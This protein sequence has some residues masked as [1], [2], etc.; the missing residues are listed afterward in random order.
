MS[1]CGEIPIVEGNIEVKGKIAYASQKPWI[2]SGT[3]RQN[4]L[5]GA[6]LN[7]KR[8]EKTID[9]CALTEVKSNICSLAY[10]ILFSDIW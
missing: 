4:I 8:Y 1:I 3:V 10:D 6:E 9:A 7:A 2:F 5:F